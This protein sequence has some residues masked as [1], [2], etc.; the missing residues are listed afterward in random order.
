[1]RDQRTV[2]HFV[3]YDNEI[4]A[5]PA[6]VG[7]TSLESTNVDVS[8]SY[9]EL[10]IPAALTIPLRGPVE[11]RLYVG[12][13]VALELSCRVAYRAGDVVRQSGCAEQSTDGDT[14]FVKTMRQIKRRLSSELHD[15]TVGFLDI[16]TIH[17][18]F[19]CQRFKI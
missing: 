3:F 9:L 1:M 19:K 6:V 4:T 15:N 16:H 11:P 17:H 8:L 12:P 5:Q 14:G 2:H 13:T 7:R 18:I 10:L